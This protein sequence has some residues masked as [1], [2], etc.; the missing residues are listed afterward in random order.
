MTLSLFGE[1]GREELD[2][3]A[4][5]LRGFALRDEGALLQ[6]LNDVTEMAPFRH[7]VTPGG[8]SHVGRDDQ[9]RQAGVG[10]GQD[11]VSL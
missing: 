9:L 10:D 7:M 4:V 1:I 5:M 8:L 11:R 6:A 2:T 3:G